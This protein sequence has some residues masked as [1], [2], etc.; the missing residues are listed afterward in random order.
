MNTKSKSIFIILLTLLIGLILGALVS[1]LFIKYK[2]EKL[3]TYRTPEGLRVYLEE[4]IEPD[5]S[6]CDSVNVILDEL[7]QNHSDIT[8]RTKTEFW[9]SFDSTFTRLEPHLKTE[10]TLR[11][12]NKMNEYRYK[13][14]EN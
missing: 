9:S 10:Q 2:V 4:I 7:Y 14:Q 6:Q 8:V 3:L 5:N 13:K 11:L 12:R 1:A